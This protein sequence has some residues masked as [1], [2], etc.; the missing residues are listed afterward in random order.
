MNVDIVSPQEY[1]SLAQFLADFPERV[2][3]ADFWSSRF[4]LWWDENPAFRP[5][6]PRGWV[7]RH[8]GR[9]GGFLAN[10][11]SFM[12]VGGEPAV[13]FSISTWMVLPDFREASLELL[14]RQ[15]E[16]SKGTLLFDT[17][18]SKAVAEILENL[19]FEPLPWG[20]GK[21]SVVLLRP[22]A[23][24]KARLKSLSFLPVLLWDFVGACLAA[25][26]SWR[27]GCLRSDPSLVVEEA[28]DCGPGLDGLWE[29]T[30]DNYSFT[31]VRTRE[32]LRWHCFE[33]RHL[34]KKLFICRKGDQV[35]GFMIM[36]SQVRQGLRTLDCLDFWADPEVAGSFEALLCFLRDYAASAGYSLLTF[37]HF[38][39]PFGR[40]LREAGLFEVLRKQ[41]SL[42]LVGSA[43]SARMLTADSYFVL[44]QGD[45][46]TSH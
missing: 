2:G 8:N 39:L 38:S 43:C 22:A 18:P 16:E 34:E 6:M 35:S 27:L 24:L 40:M 14:S 28:K 45:Y 41:V 25:V 5:D 21:E 4:R 11:P 1:P 23:C 13:V 36:K 26:Q 10:V 44:L 20:E 7:L 30:K 19:G 29:R 9:T 37:C 42:C 3:D 12:L 31:N 15:I 33:D 32:M 17:T 46:G